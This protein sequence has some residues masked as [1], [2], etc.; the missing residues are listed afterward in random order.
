MSG[1]DQN[2]R[3]VFTRYSLLHGERKITSELRPRLVSVGPSSEFKGYCIG[4]EGVYEH[5]WRRLANYTRMVSRSGFEQ[6]DHAFG[7]H[8]INHVDGD[9]K[10][11]KY[12]R[13]CPVRYLTRDE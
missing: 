4:C 3:I 10:C 8:A 11:A 12:I 13:E 5:L 9:L 7:I 1:L 6:F 2:A